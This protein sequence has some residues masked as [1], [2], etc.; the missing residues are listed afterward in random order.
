MMLRSQLASVLLKTPNG[1]LV[2]LDQLADIR[3]LRGPIIINR[4]EA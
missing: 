2:R 1:E 4:E 3:T